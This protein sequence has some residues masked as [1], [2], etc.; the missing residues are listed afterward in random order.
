MEW[1]SS[2]CRRRSLAWKTM[3]ADSTCGSPEIALILAPIAPWLFL[4]EHHDQLAF[5]IS[6]MNLAIAERQGWPR[7]RHAKCCGRVLTMRL[8]ISTP[9]VCRCPCGRPARPAS[10]S[11][12]WRGGL[13]GMSKPRSRASLLHCRDDTRAG[14]VLWAADLAARLNI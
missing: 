14:A 4:L 8:T 12:V 11:E 5:R 13:C 1:P 3:V 2:D 7:R 6:G 9:G 10:C